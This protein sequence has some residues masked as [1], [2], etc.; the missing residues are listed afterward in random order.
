MLLVLSKVIPAFLFPAGLVI[1]LCLLTAWLAFRKG[2]R[3]AGFVALGAA[4]VLYAAASPLVSNGLMRGLERHYPPVAE[5]PDAAAIVLLGGGMALMVDPRIYPETNAAGDRIIHAARL[6]QQGHAPLVVTTGGYI[7]FAVEVPGS[8]A[9]LYARLL[10]ELFGLP[11]NA[12]VRMGRSLTTHDDAVLTA[13][14]FD[15]LGIE[16]E[17][18]LVTSASHMPRAVGL[19][20]KQGFIVHPAPTDYRGNLHSPFKAFSLLPS[21]HALSETTTALHEYLGLWAYRML[22]RM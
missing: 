20:R 13:E 22:G 6:W 4:V 10:T 8:E 17:I 19:F 2:A 11:E 3:A 14:L 15:S 9:E 12:T 16:K 5:S 21:G 1:V 7:K 18:L